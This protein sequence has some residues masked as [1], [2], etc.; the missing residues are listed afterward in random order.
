M[1]KAL[2]NLANVCGQ[3]HTPGTETDLYY[4]CSCELNGFPRTKEA[5]G[6]TDDGDSKI[7][8]EP[9][10]FNTS[11]AGTGYWRH[12]RIKIDSG[13]VNDVLEGEIGSQTFK[14]S[15][16]FA[17][18]GTNEK[19]LAFADSLAAAS[20][21]LVMM[22]RT[23]TGKLR[24]LGSDKRPAYVE[25]AEIGTGTA[26]TDSNSGV[27]VASASVGVTAPIYDDA[28]HGIDITPNP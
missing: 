26:T 11:P 13:A 15:I 4:A 22:I 10:V 14:S 2:K 23:N 21:Y 20:G 6:G 7:L 28:T 27:Y 12:A 16:P 17:I 25:S 1:S 3:Q 19:Q 24:V 8:D 18:L 5:L 9:F